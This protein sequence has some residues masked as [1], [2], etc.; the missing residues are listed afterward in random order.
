V[1]GANKSIRPKLSNDGVAGRTRYFVGRAFLNIRQN[2]F[3]SAVTVIT[4]ALA[5]LILSLFLLVLVNLEDAAQE[6]GRQVQVNVYLDKEPSPQEL[7]ELKTRILA[8]PAAEA[9]RYISKSEALKRFRLRLKGQET[10]LEGV[11]ADVLPASLEISLKRRSRTSEGVEEFVGKLKG[12]QGVGEV[13]YGE[14]WVRRLS[15]FV[16]FTRLIVTLI[17]GF[18]LI[19]VLFIVSN[20]I[21]L[22]IY[23]RR[24]ELELLSLVGATRL[25][26]KAPFLIEGMVQGFA[27]AIVAL[28]LLTISYYGF[29]YN[30]GDFFRFGHASQGLLFLP[31]S[32][33]VCILAAGIILGFVGSLTSLKRFVTF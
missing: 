20:T 33:L 14:E 8:L 13:Q 10:L 28:F 12:I 24:D 4:I 31:A 11:S 32:H 7:N 9:V 16:Q 17:A 1:T 21:K 23:A 22:T 29:L 27:G 5:L 26:I 25:F 19:A 30:A 2:P 3:I 6:W 18:L 15:T